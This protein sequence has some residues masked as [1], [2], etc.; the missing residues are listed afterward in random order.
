MMQFTEYRV[1]AGDTL[2]TIAQRF[3]TTVQAI[4]AANPS[5]TSPDVIMVG[6][7]IRIPVMGMHPSPPTMPPP[8]PPA[9]PPAPAPPAVAVVPGWCCF[10]LNPVEKRVPNPGVVLSHPAETGHVFVATMG[11]PDP[12]KFGSDF[13]IYTAWILMRDGTPRNFIDL[14]PAQLPGFWVNHKEIPSLAMTDKIRVT[15]ER[16]GHG[17]SPMGPYVLEGRFAQCAAEFKG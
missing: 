14:A 6:Q 12:S 10:V 13:N 9:A 17:M 15:P 11:M 4:M 16:R 5:I 8:A 7:V 1:Q 2:T 3:G